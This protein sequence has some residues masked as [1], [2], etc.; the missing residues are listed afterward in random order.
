MMEDDEE[1]DEDMMDRLLS[2]ADQLNVERLRDTSYSK[3]P[4]GTSSAYSKND[5]S[6]TDQTNGGSAAAVN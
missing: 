3:G 5:Q 2:E 4:I 1:E 6:Q